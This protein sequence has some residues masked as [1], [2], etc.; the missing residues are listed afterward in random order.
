MEQTKK[1][2]ETKQ[3]NEPRRQDGANEHGKAGQRT[4]SKQFEAI[5]QLLKENKRLQNRLLDVQSSLS[6][7]RD[8]SQS[9]TDLIH[10]SWEG[11]RTESVGYDEIKN[12]VTSLY[13]LSENITK[14][15]RHIVKE[16]AL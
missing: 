3:P 14:H 15:A 9:L 11:I 2:K 4:E 13:L 6:N 16:T 1:Q 10:I 12:A 7:L 8:N 5:E